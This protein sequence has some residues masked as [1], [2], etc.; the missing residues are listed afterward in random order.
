MEQPIM[1]YAL[2]KHSLILVELTD[3][4]ITEGLKIKKLEC[5]SLENTLTQVL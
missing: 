3:Q 5:I 2:F 1:S 4:Q